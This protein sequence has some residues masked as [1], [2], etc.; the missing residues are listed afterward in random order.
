MSE[1][2][3]PVVILINRSL[4]SFGAGRL[5]GRSGVEYGQS[6]YDER[7]GAHVC[8]MSLSQWRACKQ[9]VTFGMSRRLSQ[10]EVDFE[11]IATPAAPDNEPVGEVVRHTSESL[12]EVTNF[13]KLLS[14]AKR[15][16]V[17]NADSINSAAELREAILAK[18]G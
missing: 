4:P 1:N 12:A 3:E 11:E 2:I 10:W 15:S 17:E 6:Y 9:D 5:T 7:H 14:F 16:G 18:Q 13:R 8:R